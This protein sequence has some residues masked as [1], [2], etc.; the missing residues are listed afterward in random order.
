NFR[1]AARL[2]G[3]GI[4]VVHYVAPTVW[5]WRPGRARAIAPL[6]RH[7]LALLP[8]EP[9]LFERWGLATTY[10]GHPAL[11]TVAD[12]DRV[13]GAGRAGAPRICLLPGSRRSELRRLL[14][15]YGQAL[16]IL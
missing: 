3:S 5:A 15:V 13:E 2:A 1:L 12:I 11:E 16:E 8:F 14:P 10:V 6:F 9:P 7:L 4:P